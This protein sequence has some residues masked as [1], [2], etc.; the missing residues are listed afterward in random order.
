MATENRAITTVHSQLDFAMDRY[1]MFHSTH[2][3]YG[4][5]AE[6]F[7]EVMDALHA[8]DNIQLYKELSQVAAVA[9]KAMMML[10]CKN[11]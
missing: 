5:L 11:N 9:I 10:D 6:E 2:E 8:N 1:P 4:V 7:K 3:A